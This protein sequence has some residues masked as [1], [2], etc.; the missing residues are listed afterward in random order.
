[1]R[2][3]KSE[4]ISAAQDREAAMYKVIF[5]DDEILIRE[6]VSENTP[7]SETGFVLAGTAENGREAIKLLERERP[8]LLL[9]DIR[10]PIMD[11]LE[12][13]AY[14]QEHF[15]DMKV[16]IIS[17]HDE[18]EYAKRALKYGVSEYILKPITA[19]ELR[20]EL[21]K[22]K[23]KLDSLNSEREN[24]KKIQRAY[25][26]NLPMLRD[27]FLN[28]VIEGN[29]AR[30]DLLEQ[31]AHFN[32]KLYGSFQAICMVVKEDSSEFFEK[33]G[34]MNKDII[35][36]AIYNISNEII[37]EY[38]QANCFRNMNDQ[39]V[40][41]CTAD[42]EKG[43]QELIKEIGGRIILEMQKCM[44]TR[45]S[46]LVG[47]TVKEPYAWQHS[48]ENAKQ[49]EEFRFLLEDS[50]FV[51]GRDFVMKTEHTGM[52]TSAWNERL[53]LLIKTNQSKELKGAVEELFQEFR[54]KLFERKVI[55]IHIQNIV[56]T[57]LITLEESEMDLGGSF[58]KESAFISKLNE[59]EHLREI[60]E[61]FLN[62]CLALA[63]G[64]VGKRESVNQKQAVLALDYIEKNY[65][66]AG[67]SLNTVCE[68]LS[69]STSYFSTIFKAY[70]GETFIETLTRV[71][72]EKAKKLLKTTSL[73]NYEVALE[74]GYSDPHY[75]SSI[76]KRQ[77]GKTPGEYA[78]SVRN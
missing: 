23:E 65:M 12:L 54:E 40:F 20:V 71:R 77:T 72:I 42:S 39:T 35:E 66:N 38:V 64:I 61:E 46:I 1:M 3:C 7:W 25:N 16:M 45:V 6:A 70:T 58:E 31:L 36:F 17:G 59:Y 67:M 55:F 52:K 57:V 63:K 14:V 49:A 48:Y 32:V 34:D 51:Y 19:D 44:K 56:L 10:M 60:K 29:G 30:N 2:G 28:R 9:T 73:K 5:V 8:D 11:G 22:I 76:F 75:F 50:A 41:L 53:V 26:E 24:V 74:V 33:Y 27:L 78:K 69:V 13:S 21:L 15:P 68:Y 62:Y 37:E 47:D 43:L 4:S 18:F